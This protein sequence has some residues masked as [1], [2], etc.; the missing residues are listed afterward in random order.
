MNNRNILRHGLNL[1][2]HKYFWGPISLTILFFIVATSSYS[3]NGNFDLYVNFFDHVTMVSA[4]FLCLFAHNAL[5]GKKDLTNLIA[6]TL[7]S[8]ILSILSIMALKTHSF[9]GHLSFTLC[10]ASAFVFF[11]IFKEMISVL[12]KQ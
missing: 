8:V 3:A 10:L 7:L 4:L 2:A 1:Y 9:L 6:I 12:D 5:N 11:W